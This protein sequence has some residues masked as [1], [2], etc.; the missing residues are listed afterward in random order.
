MSSRSRTIAVISAALIL[1]VV[2]VVSGVRY[3]SARLSAEA[4]AIDFFEDSIERL[5]KEPPGDDPL[6]HPTPPDAIESDD[7]DPTP[8]TPIIPVSPD[9]VPVDPS[10]FDFDPK[11]GVVRTFDVN[12]KLSGSVKLE[13][14]GWKYLGSAVQDLLVFIQ[15]P[16]PGSYHSAVIN[17]ETATLSAIEQHL[18]SPGGKSVACQGRIYS[19]SPWDTYD[20]SQIYAISGEDGSAIPLEVPRYTGGPE[21]PH[22]LEAAACLGDGHLVVRAL[23]GV[24]EDW[25]DI[26]YGILWLRAPGARDFKNLIEPQS[27]EN[28]EGYEHIVAST[29][30]ST[31]FFAYERRTRIIDPNTRG[32]VHKIEAFSDGKLKWS[33]ELSADAGYHAR[34]GAEKDGVIQ[35]EFFGSLDDI[36]G[37]AAPLSVFQ[38]DAETGENQGEQ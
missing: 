18:G 34:I 5:S 4:R 36:A 29:S 23:E 1:S 16:E 31:T 9:A 21:Y 27:S 6:P 26:L 17:V 13:G 3:E 12:G 38:L 11:A 19:P 20:D 24:Q 33:Q 35:V 32:I 14:A 7:P 30:D 15:A 2:L 10:R 25:T 22:I 37:D 28:F 8:P